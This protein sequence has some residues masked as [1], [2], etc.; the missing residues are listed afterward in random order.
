MTFFQ[1][2]CILAYK[3]DKPFFTALS[4][5]KYKVDIFPAKPI[6]QTFEKGKYQGRRI[7]KSR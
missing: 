7:L 1:K 5:T 2:F 3:T 4:T 6:F